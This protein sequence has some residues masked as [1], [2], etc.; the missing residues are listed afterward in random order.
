MFKR[1]KFFSV[2]YV[3]MYYVIFFFDVLMKL[4]IIKFFYGENVIMMQFK[5]RFE[6][7]YKK[8]RCFYII[9]VLQNDDYIFVNE[10]KI[11]MKYY[12]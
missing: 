11:V 12:F 9:Y 2:Q 4:R 7:D 1:N 10:F 5:L 8:L 6:L 3:L